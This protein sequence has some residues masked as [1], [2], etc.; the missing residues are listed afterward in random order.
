MAL[1]RRGHVALEVY[2]SSAGKA[3]GV[4][5]QA[6]LST[7]AAPGSQGRVFAAYN[8]CASV[9]GVLAGFGARL[10]QLSLELEPP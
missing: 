6:L 5:A 7:C 3:A 10:Y 8:F 2:S 1:L 4:G 9:G